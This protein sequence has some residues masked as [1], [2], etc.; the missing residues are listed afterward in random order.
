MAFT[1]FLIK[2]ITM[3]QKAPHDVAPINS[4]FTYPLR[5]SFP[6]FLAIFFYILGTLS[7]ES[8]CTFCLTC[9]ECSFLRC[10]YGL[11]CHL[12]PF[13]KPLPGIHHVPFLL[14]FFHSNDHL[15]CYM[16]CLFSTYLFLVGHKF[17][18]GCQGFLSLLFPNTSN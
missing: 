8:L 12:L 18:W 15:A 17:P 14:Y 10:L 13:Q 7:F 5:F 16:F 11:L 9:P 1:T 2:V 6:G 3:A 4:R